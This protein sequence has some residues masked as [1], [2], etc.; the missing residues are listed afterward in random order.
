MLGDSRGFPG[1]EVMSTKNGKK[2]R[3]RRHEEA[4]TSF[5]QPTPTICIDDIPLPSKSPLKKNITPPIEPTDPP[6]VITINDTINQDMNGPNGN[7]NTSRDMNKSR[8][9]SNTPQSGKKIVVINNNGSGNGKT[10]NEE[11]LLANGSGGYGN[12]NGS[13]DGQQQDTVINDHSADVLIETIV[14]DSNETEPELQNLGGGESDSSQ[15]EVLDDAASKSSVTRCTTRRSQTRYIPTPETPHSGEVEGT[16]IICGE[17]AVQVMPVEDGEKPTATTLPQPDEQVISPPT[18][19]VSPSTPLNPATP[20]QQF[21]TSSTHSDTNLSTD[22]TT[23]N[24]S[25]HAV[26]GSDITRMNNDEQLTLPGT[27]EEDVYADILENKAEEEQHQREK[28]DGK[29]WYECEFSDEGGRPRSREGSIART[30]T[31]RKSIRPGTDYRKYSLERGMSGVGSYTS[32]LSRPSTPST[33]SGLKRKN[34]PTDFSTSTPTTLKRRKLDTVPNETFNWFSYISQPFYSLKNR[35]SRSV[36]VTL[37]TKTEGPQK[38]I[39]PKLT[40]Y[41]KLNTK[42][43]LEEELDT[44]DCPSQNEAEVNMV[45]VSLGVEAMAA[46]IVVDKSATLDESAAKEKAEEVQKIPVALEVDNAGGNRKSCA[47]M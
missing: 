39:T 11:V 29:G 18:P 13:G 8:S 46:D 35:F 30:L 5:K 16:L 4:P 31:G 10:E 42:S 7:G 23:D 37:N 9:R 26:V 21:E 17:E 27:E 34:T 22:S 25:T 14:I 20:Q 38:N 24:C 33:S 44:V 28:V 45:D 47:I 19:A 2:S 3:N 12:G 43:N 15:Q 1:R 41:N 36:N 6:P 40:G 32:T